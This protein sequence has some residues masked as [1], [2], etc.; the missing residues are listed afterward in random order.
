MLAEEYFFQQDPPDFF[1]LRPTLY[2]HH[3]L[4]RPFPTA[5]LE[6]PPRTAVLSAF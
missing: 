2:Q 5:T 3:R 4:R 1:G 6:D